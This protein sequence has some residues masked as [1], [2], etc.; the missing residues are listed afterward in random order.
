MASD[1]YGKL[2]SS[3]TESTVWGEPYATRLLWV[4]MIAKADKDGC[5][6]AAVPGLARLANITLE[7]CQA[8][9]QAFLSPDPFSRTPDNDG[10]RIETIDGGWRLLNWAKYRAIRG[11]EERAAY[12]REW[13]RQHRPS[14]HDRSIADG[15]P[16]QSDT[17]RHGPTIPTGATPAAPAP[18]PEDQKLSA[19][20]EPAPAAR[21]PRSKPDLDAGF[22]EFWVAYPVKQGRLEALKAWRKAGMQDQVPKLIEHVQRMHAQDDGWRR[23]MIPRASTY[24]NGQRWEDQPKAEGAS[25]VPPPPVQRQYGS[26]VALA[27]CET[28]LEA[29]INLAK[30]HFNLHGDRERL[31]R[32]IAEA[33]ARLGGAS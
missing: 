33:K 20:A 29:A 6:Y 17:V 22:A 2:F 32:E 16:T 25:H 14:G 10:R 3:I 26:K 1:T 28:P 24:L 11:T 9:L 21:S 15:S 19:P 4:A 5:I 23:G 27:P 18:Y 13:D 8:A 31:N 7:E 12:K 30:Q